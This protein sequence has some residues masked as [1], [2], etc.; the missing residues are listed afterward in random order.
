MQ[1]KGTRIT[2]H[3]FHFE[4][5]SILPDVLFFGKYRVLSDKAKLLYCKL[6]QRVRVALELG[7]LNERG[8]VYIKVKRATMKYI[9]N[10]SNQTL[11]N[12]YTQLEEIG[13]IDI[14]KG[15]KNT[16][17]EVYILLPD[18]IE[19]TAEEVE[20]SDERILDI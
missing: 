14:H 3:N 20:L 11:Q 17:D 12:A 16:I 19:L 10:T 5:Y 7:W 13:L 4:S 8:E 1:E 9:L 6:S 2:A 15:A 18:K